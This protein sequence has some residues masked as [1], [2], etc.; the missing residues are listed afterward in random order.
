MI[1][2]ELSLEGF[3]AL[4]LALD[5][6]SIQKALKKA[7]TELKREALR[8]YARPVRTWKRSAALSGKIQGKNQGWQHDQPGRRVVWGARLSIIRNPPRY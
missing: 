3:E 1:G 6:L 5:P 8:L 4:T 2:I 7:V